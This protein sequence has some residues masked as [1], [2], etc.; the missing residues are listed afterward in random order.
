MP[1]PLIQNNIPIEVYLKSLEDVVMNAA[2]E[3]PSQISKLYTVKTTDKLY[4]D[5]QS[6][7][8]IRPFSSWNGNGQVIT[9][10]AI[11]PRFKTRITQAFFATA[12]SY[13]WVNKKFLKY[14]LLNTQAHQLVV[15]AANTKEM[16]A[17]SLV[18]TGFT[19]DFIDGVKIFSATHPL[20][21]GSV[22]SNLITGPI[23]HTTVRNGITRVRKIKDDQGICMHLKPIRM[24][25]PVGKEGDAWEVLRSV[26]RSD[27]ANRADNWLASNWK[28]IEIE[29]CDSLTSDT[30][31]G[32]QTNYT[33]V[34]GNPGLVYETS[35]ELEQKQYELN[36]SEDTVHQAIFGIGYGMR[37]WRELVFS[38]GS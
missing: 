17:F 28:S 4:S 24:W 15:Q 14:D 11:S 8:G 37:D 35:V 18:N 7:A 36:G 12:V 20:A 22:D 5:V 13:S 25:V 21:N 2:K 6:F 3:I 26:G 23:S 38:T 30:S 19:T 10:Q 1:G 27:T 34:S 31:W 9:A 29:G 32:F 33:Q 16:L